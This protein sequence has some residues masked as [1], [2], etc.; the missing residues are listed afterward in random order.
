MFWG[1]GEVDTTN[2][3]IVV[4]VLGLLIGLVTLLMENHETYSNQE[5]LDGMTPFEQWIYFSKDMESLDARTEYLLS[6]D[7]NRELKKRF[8]EKLDQT[9]DD[10]E[11]MKRGIVNEG[12]G[13]SSF[14]KTL[15]ELIAKSWG[16]WS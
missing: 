11:E 6:E 3:I 5:F 1:E 8:G 15:P 16:L 7:G 2:L 13:F 9:P 10:W 12:K 4:V 14:L